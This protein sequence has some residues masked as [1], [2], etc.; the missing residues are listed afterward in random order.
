MS[1]ATLFETHNPPPFLLAFFWSACG[2]KDMRAKVKSAGE[3][4][5][6]NTIGD[7][8]KVTHVSGPQVVKVFKKHH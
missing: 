6:A 4:D 7:T 8:A 3:V 1:T 5:Y 2:P